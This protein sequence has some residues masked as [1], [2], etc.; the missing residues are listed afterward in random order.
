MP[1]QNEPPAPVR[2]PTDRPSSPSSRSMASAK[3]L[4]DRGVHRVPGLGPVDGDDQDPVALFDQDDFFVVGFFA[5][6]G[7]ASDQGLART[8]DWVLC[9]TRTR[10]NSTRGPH[11]HDRY[12]AVGTHQVGS[13]PDR[14][15]DGDHAAVPQALLPLG[16]ARSGE[17]AARRRAAGVQ[18]LRR[19]AP[20]GRADPRPSTSTR[21]TATTGRS[22]RSATTCSRSGRR[23]TS[24]RR[25]ATS[26]PTTRTPTRRCAPAAWSWCSPAATTT[27]TGRRCRRTRSTS[28]AA[29]A[30]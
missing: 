11:G 26:A 5:H 28:A 14:A 12:R 30:T 21:S 18:P 6:A 8:R 1:A 9:K 20:D 3:P 15:R 7:D 24:S 23:A 29:P 17:H 25:S 2:M 4:A 22:T 27:C 16:G 19:H 10:S 13:G